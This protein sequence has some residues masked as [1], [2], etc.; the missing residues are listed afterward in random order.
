MALR[1]Q[2]PVNSEKPSNSPGKPLSHFPCHFNL[3]WVRW[4]ILLIDRGREKCSL[5]M[6]PNQRSV[7]EVEA[8]R[9]EWQR[10]R[11]SPASWACPQ[12][13]WWRSWGRVAAKQ[14]WVSLPDPLAGRLS[15]K[16]ERRRITEA[17]GQLKSPH[18]VRWRGDGLVTRKRLCLLGA[19]TS[20]GGA[21]VKSA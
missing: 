16:A 5:L 17:L 7:C 11:D 13:R 6:S 21:I 12:L 10:S 19:N 3:V 14:S 1:L 8:L 4:K 2:L 9:K 15:G 18:A 20:V